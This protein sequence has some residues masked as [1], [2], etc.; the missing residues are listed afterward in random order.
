M[1]RRLKSVLLGLL[2]VVVAPTG[3]GKRATEP[4]TTS[5]PALPDPRQ[6]TPRLVRF[7][8]H[9]WEVRRDAL[10]EEPGP[11]AF[12][13]NPDNVWVDGQGSLHLRITNRDGGW[14]CAEAFCLDR[15]PGYG[16]YEYTV[17]GPVDAFDRWVVG[18]LFLYA[19]PERDG[20]ATEI[21]IEFARWGANSG[22]NLQLTVQPWQLPD[23]RRQFAW[24]LA[25]APTT[26]WFEWRPG[27]ARFFSAPGAVAD[28]RKA[29]VSWTY[30]GADVPK[31][32]RERVHLNLWLFRTRPPSDAREVELVVTAFRYT[33]L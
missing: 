12:S 13:D 31:P 11:N 9:D 4:P 18:G 3:C 17:G 14:Q 29:V 33:R 26:H 8:G 24:Q 1:D 10:K 25:D 15:L 6:Q 28:P 23:H 21:D 2:A 7:S 32:G 27:E 19:P 30:R 5:A 22:Y 20:Q 16:R